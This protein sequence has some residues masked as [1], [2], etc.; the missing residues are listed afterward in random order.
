MSAE[1]SKNVRVCVGYEIKWACDIREFDDQ[2]TRDFP[3]IKKISDWLWDM[4]SCN[5]ENISKT[6]REW[7]IIHKTPGHLFIF[8]SLFSDDLSQQIMYPFKEPSNWPSGPLPSSAIWTEILYDDYWD[9][10]VEMRKKEDADPIFSK[11]RV[12]I[13]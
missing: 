2:K 8:L 5:V 1:Q 9:F 12:R 6:Q 7:H 3:M 10:I 11:T 13:C 4:T